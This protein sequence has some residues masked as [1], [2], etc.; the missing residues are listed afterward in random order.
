MHRAFKLAMQPPAGPVLISV[1]ALIA[2]IKAD[3]CKP[4]QS[5]GVSGKQAH[6]VRSLLHCILYYISV[7]C[8]Y[9]PKKILLWQRMNIT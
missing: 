5:M 2:A 6:I 9:Q 4:V 3:I 7:T 1:S 8:W